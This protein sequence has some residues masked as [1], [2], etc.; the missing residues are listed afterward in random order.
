MAEKK[1]T[2]EFQVVDKLAGTKLSE[3]VE[4]MIH[5][6][7]HQYDD[8]FF[9][10][11][12][13]EAAIPSNAFTQHAPDDAWVQRVNLY[14]E[15]GRAGQCQ[16]LHPGIQMGASGAYTRLQLTGISKFKELNSRNPH[17]KPSLLVRSRAPAPSDN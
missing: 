11:G 16:L 5:L 12:V 17:F 8:L 1:L 10:H 14:L 3:R 9:W 6:F 2:A 4:G 13:A 15:D 7:E